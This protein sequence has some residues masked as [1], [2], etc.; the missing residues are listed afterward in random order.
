MPR[1]NINSSEVEEWKKSMFSMPRNN[2]NSSE[3][4]W[5]KSINQFRSLSRLER[6]RIGQL[7]FER[8]RMLSVLW[9]TQ[10]SIDEVQLDILREHEFVQIMATRMHKFRSIVEERRIQAIQNGRS[11]RPRSFVEGIPLVGKMVSRYYDGVV[12]VPT[13]VPRPANC[14]SFEV[15]SLFGRVIANVLSNMTVHALTIEIQIMTGMDPNDQLLMNDTL[16]II[17]HDI[18]KQTVLRAYCKTNPSFVKNRIILISKNPRFNYLLSDSR[19][20]SYLNTPDYKR[21]RVEDIRRTIEVY[22]NPHMVSPGGAW[23]RKNSRLIR[24]TQHQLRCISINE[25]KMTVSDMLRIHPACIVVSSIVLQ[26]ISSMV[27]LLN[28]PTSSDETIQLFISLA[29]TPEYVYQNKLYG[30][31]F[32]EAHASW[33]ERRDFPIKLGKHKLHGNF[34]DE[35]GDALWGR[36]GD[37]PI[38]VEEER[39]RITNAATAAAPQGERIVAIERAREGNRERIEREESARIAE[40]AKPAA[41]ARM[42]QAA[43]R[44]RLTPAV[45]SSAAAART[46]QTATRSRLAQAAL[47]ISRLAQAAASE[48]RTRI[49]LASAPDRERILAASSAQD[50]ERILAVI[51][52][53]D[54]PLTVHAP[55]WWHSA[56]PILHINLIQRCDLKTTPTR[57]EESAWWEKFHRPECFGILSVGSSNRLNVFIRTAT[58]ERLAF[59]CFYDAVCSYS[60]LTGIP[61]IMDTNRSVAYDNAYD[62]FQHAIARKTVSLHTAIPAIPSETTELSFCQFLS[63]YFYT[64]ASEYSIYSML[65]NSMQFPTVRWDTG[66]TYVERISHNLITLLYSAVYKCPQVRELHQQNLTNGATHLYR[67]MP[68]P[69]NIYDMYCQDAGV[70]NRVTFY[71]FQGFSLNFNL[72]MKSFAKRTTINTHLVVLKIIVNDNTTARYIAHYSA[73]E[74]EEE[75][76]ALPCI[77]YIVTDILRFND[78]RVFIEY[79]TNSRVG[80]YDLSDWLTT[81]YFKEYLVITLSEESYMTHAAAHPL[82]G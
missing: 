52:A 28:H 68:I 81:G 46:L 82:N 26:D 45:A 27:Q 10:S 73:I 7:A 11:Q 22:Y 47:E 64:G 42:L 37:F 13:I 20:F 36:W 41:A 49:A 17:N 6:D 12:P 5:K 55:Y 80:I 38:E 67:C 18:N 50:K 74:E 31:F 3:V 40:A 77:P 15:I 9:P 29:G 75:V 61:H 72:A 32:S 57:E 65:R 25:I 2:I 48:E 23:V 78:S 34:F 54:E 76:L 16:E 66:H 62:I 63:I 19:A 21:T 69:E 79:L 30:N 44:S 43:T 4:E 1:N 60:R 35:A 8:C 58:D 24:Y 51:R 53:L 14:K 71:C 59:E 70:N 56:I 33:G 39:N